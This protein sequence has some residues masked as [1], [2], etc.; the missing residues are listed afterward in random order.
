[1][2]TSDIQCENCHIGTRRPG[3]ATV[4]YWVENQ[5]VLM[6]GV[7][8]W[9]CDVCGDVEYELENI[10]RLE[11]LLGIDH[12]FSDAGSALGA[13]TSADDLTSL[14]ASRRRSV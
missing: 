10:A 4:T 12:P 7:P 14:I 13:A 11:K 3:R 2:T 6:P 5:L 1:M 8:V 9:T